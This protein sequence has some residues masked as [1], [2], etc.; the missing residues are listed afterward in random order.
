M[1]AP[2]D[3][4]LIQL[5]AADLGIDESFVEKDWHV[6][7]IIA[8]LSRLTFGDF[9]LVFSGGTSLSK[10]HGLIRRFSEDI[11]FKVIPP[12]AEVFISKNAFKKAC[13]DLRQVVITTLQEAGWQVDANQVKAGN[14]NQFF[15]VP[16]EYEPRFALTPA[17]RPH[18]QVEMSVGAPALRWVE[19]PVRS[20]VSQARKE[21]PEV[22]AIACVSAVETAADKLS[23][24]V[25]RVLARS[26]GEGDDPAF[27]RHVHDLAILEA[28]ALDNREFPELVL[29]LLEEDASRGK[30]PPE[31]SVL[32][33]AERVA[34]AL[35]I[36][37]E[38]SGYRAEYERF[39]TG[40]SY[41]AEGE[42]PSFEHAL[43]GLDRLVKLV[44]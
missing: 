38:D 30:P 14:S 1:S 17:L 29:T 7:R 12:P 42:T 35:D 25:W 31:V 20:F 32:A 41:A 36:L 28:M 16:V 18:I 21:T 3:Q 2:P 5:I 40:M 23:A 37:R 13:S 43:K 9:R 27:I 22:E 15:S 26:R 6:V 4:E 19:L 33:P 39:V 34:R 44:F 10:A 8:V 24:L 11:D